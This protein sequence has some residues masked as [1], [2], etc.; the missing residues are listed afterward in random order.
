MQVV[1]EKIV[2]PGRRLATHRGKAVFTDEGLAG[3]LIE[4]EPVLEKKNYIEARTVKILKESD[5]RVKPRCAHYLACSAYQSM[6]YDHQIETKKS[7]L[8][9]IM[10][11]LDDFDENAI[12]LVPSSKIWHYRNK[13]RFHVMWAGGKAYPAYNVPGS[14]EKFVK[15]GE[16][17]LVAESVSELLSALLRIISE[18]QMRSLQDV[19]ARVGRAKNE[20]LLNLYWKSVCEPKSL[21]LILSGLLPRFPLAGIVSL[22]KYKAGYKEITEWGRNF[23][24]EKIGPALFYVGAQSFFQVNPEMLETVIGDIKNLA[25]FRGTEL[26]GDLYCGLGTFGIILAREVKEVY[27]VESDP[28]SVSFLKKNIDLNR[29][30]NF[31]I[32]EGPIEEWASRILEKKMEVLILDPPRKGLGPGL[33]RELLKNPTP[34]VIYLSCNPATLA[35]DLKEL[36]SAYKIK[37]IRAYDFFPHTPHIE[38]LAFLEG[39]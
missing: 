17:H 37:A 30:G 18:K 7:Q 13:V 24:E 26:L 38:T 29:A 4:A 6:L 12:E 14:R 19:E 11:E 3:E 16:C 20:L 5:K 39:K 36:Q 31:K 34:L 35:R 9:E 23:I 8:R 1:I 33:V 25:A 10:A 28:A 22:Q 15:I 2:Y 32:F 27:G 21:D